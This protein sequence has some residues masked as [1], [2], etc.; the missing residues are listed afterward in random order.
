[1]EEEGEKKGVGKQNFQGGGR[2]IK[3]KLFLL[4]FLTL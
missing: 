4:I 1:M 2:K 3:R